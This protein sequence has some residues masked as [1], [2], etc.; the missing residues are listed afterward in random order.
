MPEKMDD[1]PEISKGGEDFIELP[2]SNSP[3]GGSENVNND[4]STNKPGD[5]ESQPSDCRVNE[6]QLNGEILVI[7]KS[8]YSQVTLAANKEHGSAVEVN[9]TIVENKISV[10]AE[11]GSV[12]EDGIHKRNGSPVSNHES[13][14]VS[15]SKRPRIT[16][17]EQHASVHVIYNSLTRESKRKLEELLQKWSEWHAQH[18]SKDSMA[19]LESGEGTY[20]PALSVGLDKP[21]AVSFWIDGQTRSTQSNEVITLDNSS[22]PLYDRGYSFGLTS[23]DGPSNLDGGLEIVDGSRCFNCGSYNHAMKECP[24]PRDNA[25]V[26]NARKQH[27]AKRNQNSMSRNPTRYYQD[28][29]GGKFDGLRPGVLDPETRKLLGLAEVDP[30]PW[31][32]RMR[33]MGYPPG[34]LDAEDEDQPSG[35]EIFG[36]EV[37]VAA[38]KQETEDGEILDMD[39]SPPHDTLKP[40][41]PKKMSVRFPGVN[42]PIPENAD[43]WRWGARAWKFDLPRNRS[44][45]R[46][47]NSTEPAAASRPSFLEDRWNRDHRDDG[48]PGVDPGNGSLPSTF[49]P[50]Y[51]SYDSRGSSYGRSW[52]ERDR[53]SSLIREMGSSHDDDRWSPYSS[54]SSS[55]RKDRHEDRHHRSWR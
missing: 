1:S 49:S 8:E 30:P 51:S 42:A 7:E 21:S 34:Y 54:D 16:V 3:G 46:F 10:L 29:P 18:N 19:E 55:H 2:A 50:R 43:E 12:V 37:V 36:E 22:V 53:R 33:E 23:T 38:V 9:N 11:N 48:P 44:N 31:L 35:I 40:E 26:N 47:H 24:K 6:G 45:N 15:G 4:S 13:Y 25:A 14:A 52:P 20:F 41:P 27:K 32:N 39:I 17:D 28:T 5:S